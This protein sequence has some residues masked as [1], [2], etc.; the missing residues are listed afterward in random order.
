KEWTYIM[1]QDESDELYNRI[2]DPKEQNNIIKKKLLIAKKLREEL[3]DFIALTSEA[4]TQLAEKVDID[5]ELK[6]KLKS[7]GYLH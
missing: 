3:E 1:N 2:N 6:E 4:K 7:L 5:E